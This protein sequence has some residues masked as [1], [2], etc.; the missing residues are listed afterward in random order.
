MLQILLLLGQRYKQCW[1]ERDVWST[2]CVKLKVRRSLNIHIIWYF[3]CFI[4]LFWN[5]WIK[6]NLYFNY[7]S[8]ITLD[9]FWWNS[10]LY[11]AFSQFQS[12]ITL[13][14]L[15]FEIVD[16]YWVSTCCCSKIPSKSPFSVLQRSFKKSLWESSSK[17]LSKT[18]KNQLYNS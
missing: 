14:K 5:S 17:S 6:L 15:C 2:W 4:E 1:E 11:W 16:G 18:T 10:K 3:R 7:S 12:L 8:L 13:Q 9:Y